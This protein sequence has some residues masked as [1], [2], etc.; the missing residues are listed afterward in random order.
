MKHIVLAALAATVLLPLSAPMASAAGRVEKACL[1]ADRAGSAALCNCIQ[2]VADMTLSRSDQKKAAGF[3]ED[4]EEAQEIR[5]SKK[6]SDN[7]FWARYKNFGAAA[8]TYCA[9][10]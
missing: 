1:R 6:A 9:R 3:F 8:E 2:Q 7:E 5:A 10:R 4:P